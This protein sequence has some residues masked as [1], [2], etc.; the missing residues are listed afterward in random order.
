MVINLLYNTAS[1]ISL[2]LYKLSLFKIL[3][4][5]PKALVCGV[6]VGSAYNSS[7]LLNQ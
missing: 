7:Y 6:G 4:Q 2:V 3:V 5:L 1:N